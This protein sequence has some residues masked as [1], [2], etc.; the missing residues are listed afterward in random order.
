MA[1]IYRHLDC[2]EALVV[3]LKWQSDFVLAGRGD[4]APGDFGD[5]PES[6]LTP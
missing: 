5:Q 2:I 6:P 1:T 4:E 3:R